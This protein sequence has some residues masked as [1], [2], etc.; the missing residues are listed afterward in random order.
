M[1]RPSDPNA[2]AATERV[3]AL[4]LGLPE[5]TE[6]MSHG[7]AAWF[8]RRSPQF[9]TMA[10]RHHDD[11]VALWAA[12]PPGAQQDW[13][14][15]APNHYFVPPYVG[16]RGWIGVYLDGEPDWDAI[17]DIVED[18]YRAVAPS[19]LVQRLDA[20]RDSSPG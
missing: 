12:A 15:R 7:E 8:V 2:A 16:G 20:L 14:R 3:R 13:V 10:D 1:S 17:A 5:A 6:R 11:R 9:V 18:A 4:C 19:K